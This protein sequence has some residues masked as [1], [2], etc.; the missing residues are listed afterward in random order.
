MKRVVNLKNVRR[1][2]GVILTILF[3][4]GCSSGKQETIYMYSPPTSVDGRACVDEC[5]QSKV[6]CNNQCNIA[7]PQCLA[8]EQQK[9]Q[10]HYNAYVG[11]QQTLGQS[12]SRSLQSFY[13]PERCEHSGCDC[14]ANFDVC[15]QLCGTRTEIHDPMLAN[16]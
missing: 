13:H 8:H 5:Q 15:H 4:V 6:I 2:F 7:S 9:A 3:M 16:E 10:E 12:P 11:R 1:C 14:D